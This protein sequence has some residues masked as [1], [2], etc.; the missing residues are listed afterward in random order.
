MFYSHLQHS[1]FS[2]WLFLLNFLFSLLLNYLSF[3]GLS[4]NPLGRTL[5]L[6][7]VGWSRQHRPLRLLSE[8]WYPQDEHSN[9]RLVCRVILA[10]RYLIP[11]PRADPPRTNFPSKFLL[12]KHIVEAFLLPDRYYLYTLSQTI[13]LQH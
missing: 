1:S 10:A 13:K 9:L 8:V 12:N 3:H 11:F 7:S 2:C 4:A 6:W 5:P